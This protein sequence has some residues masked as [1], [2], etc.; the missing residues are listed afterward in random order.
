MCQ[1]SAIPLCNTAIATWTLIANRRWPPLIRLVSSALKARAVKKAPSQ[2]SNNS[3]N[4]VIIVKKKSVPYVI[5]MLLSTCRLSRTVEVNYRILCK[6]A[7]CLVKSFQQKTL[8]SW[9]KGNKRHSTDIH[10]MAWQQDALQGPQKH[11]T[12][13]KDI[14]S[15]WDENHAHISKVQQ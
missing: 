14:K 11:D 12:A 9:V 5:P 6:E 1:P 2:W 15:Q 3:L 13:S 7:G 4:I 8:Q 10:W